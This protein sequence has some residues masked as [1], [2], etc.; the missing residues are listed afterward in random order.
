MPVGKS[1]D[2]EEAVNEAVDK[3]FS[4]TANVIKLNV[5][6]EQIGVIEATVNVFERG[7]TIQRVKMSRDGSYWVA[8]TV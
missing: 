7:R 3:S 4:G 5:G 2:Y 1:E 8:E 6:E